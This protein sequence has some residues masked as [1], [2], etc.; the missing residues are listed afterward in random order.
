MN[1]MNQINFSSEPD[2]F[3]SKN[4]KAP[5]S[6]DD[7][8][9]YKAVIY[10]NLGPND[11]RL[12]VRIIPN[13]LGIKNEEL[14]FLPRYPAFIKGQMITG[15]TEYDKGIKDA[16]R[17]YVLAT[18][19]FTVGYILGLAND[20]EGNTEA[21]FKESI[22]WRKIK[23]FLTERSIK[24]DD[25]EYCDIQIVTRTSEKDSGGLLIL[26]NFRTGDYFILNQSGT[27]LTIQ[28]NKIV[29]RVGSPGSPGENVNF[30]QIKMTGER[31]EIITPT[32]DI[33]SPEVFLGHSGAYVAATNAPEGIAVGV[34]GI[35]FGSVT[36]I[37]V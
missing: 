23:S 6:S 32:L 4:R 16:S 8:H 27:F 13:M 2:P 31:I 29:M 11:D 9:V 36:T 19:D 14:D 5:S 21:R 1:Q 17:V 33:T 20:F 26:Y 15:Y 28:S 37:H 34:D 22:H 18:S 7:L 12:Q 30:S 25:F 10:K 35:T 3:Y 24:P